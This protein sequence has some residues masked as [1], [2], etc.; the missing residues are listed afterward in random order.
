VYSTELGHSDT[1]MEKDAVF[2]KKFFFEDCCLIIFS[3]NRIVFINE[4]VAMCGYVVV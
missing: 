2:K 3:K 1:G 4:K